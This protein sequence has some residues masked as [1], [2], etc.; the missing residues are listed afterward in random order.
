MNERELAFTPAY[1][2]AKLIA[3]KKL[4][5][6]ELTKIYLNRIEA[7]N[8]QL[9]AFLTITFD[10]AMEAAR[11][12]EEAVMRGETL[13]P[14]HGIPTSIKDLEPTKGIR[15]TRGSLA[16]K[17]WVPDQDQLAVER[18]K[19]AGAIILGK[20]NT[21]E[22][23]QSGTTEN[24]L[25]DDCRNPWNPER[26]S[27]GSSGGAAATVV[28]G[29]N[30]IAQGSDGGGSIRIPACFCGVYGIKGT[31]GRVPRRHA[32]LTSWHPVNFSQIGPITRT[33]RDAA[34]FLRVMSGFHPE[35]EPGTIQEPP[36]DFTA[37]LGLGVRGL[38]IAWSPDLGSIPVDREVREIT[39]RAAQVFQELEAFVEPAPF[40]VDS[41]KMRKTY[42]TLA[43]PMS[44][45]NYGHLLQSQA[46]LLMPYVREAIEEGQKV[47]G[48]E[49]ALALAELE[50][51][52][53][54]VA[55]FFTRYNLLLTPT[56]AVS[57]FPC[58]QA[59]EV[60]DGREGNEKGGRTPFNYLSGY[61]PFNY[62]FNM[63]GN[64]AAS[65]PCGFSSD[66]LPIGLHIVGRKG[67]EATVLRASAAFEEARPWADK[68]PPIS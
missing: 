59:P 9:N 5:P 19:A 52:R 4:S 42:R 36:P 15:T 57:A 25:G 17:D 1:E 3:Q 67:D 7:L 29:M 58:G 16:Y 20:T 30:P 18:I 35:A 33:V 60:I 32:G 46:D 31:Q 63:S 54:Y 37:S 53:A 65:V 21:P 22:F 43:S 6:V 12:A 55:D 28:S 24:L 2:L 51:Y 13:G 14:L 64:P 10:E 11:Q 40:K 34:I 49:Y 66:G 41:E 27:G 47:T 68:L 26:V 45:I 56:L 38:R 39:E 50:Q 8:P 23:G 62:L 61:S 44:S 48:Y